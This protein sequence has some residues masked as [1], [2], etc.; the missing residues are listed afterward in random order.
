M[1]PAFLYHIVVI[2]PIF[3]VMSLS[4]LSSSSEPT[5]EQ[6]ARRQRDLKKLDTVQ[7]GNEQGIEEA[8]AEKAFKHTQIYFK[9][10][11]AINCTK[12]K[13]TKFDDEL[14]HEFLVSFPRVR[15]DVI[16]EEA[17]KRAAVKVR[18]RAFCKL[19]EYHI[20]DY[21]FGTLLRLDCKEGYSE[22][23]TT[24]VPR[25]QFLA[26]EV[27]RNR[28]GFNMCHFGTTPPNTGSSTGTNVGTENIK[29]SEDHVAV[30]ETAEC[31]KIAEVNATVESV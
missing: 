8:W 17:L 19:F 11:C 24:L 31:E 18:W 21:N 7:Y 20:E 13:L 4:V 25:V 23:N 28:Q 22:S 6:L 9:L 15:I 12:L 2:I 3:P 1:S 10:I 14:Y 26:I 29:D 5:P 30:D 16:E 27:A